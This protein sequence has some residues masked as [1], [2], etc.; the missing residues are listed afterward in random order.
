MAIAVLNPNVPRPNIVIDTRERCLDSLKAVQQARSEVYTTLETE[1]GKQNP[2]QLDQIKDVFQ[3]I[4]TQLNGL[5]QDSDYAIRCMDIHTSKQNTPEL[6]ECRKEDARLNALETKLYETAA[7]K[8][9]IGSVDPTAVPGKPALPVSQRE[10]LLLDTPENCLASLQ[11]VQIH[12]QTAL[13]NLEFNLLGLQSGLPARKRDKVIEILAALERAK[14]LADQALLCLNFYRSRWPATEP[15]NKCITEQEKLVA[16]EKIVLQAAAKSGFGGQAPTQIHLPIPDRID[17]EIDTAANCLKS[18]ETVQEARSHLLNYLSALI[19]QSNPDRFEIE[20]LFQQ[21]HQFRLLSHYCLERYRWTPEVG[22]HNT[23]SH[24]EHCEEEASLDALESTV[25]ELAVEKGWIGRTVS[26]TMID[27]PS[28]EKIIRFCKAH[29]LI[30]LGLAASA[31]ASVGWIPMENPLGSLAPALAGFLTSVAVDPK[32]TVLD[33]LSLSDF[34]LK[35]IARRALPIATWATITA[36]MC[37]TDNVSRAPYLLGTAALIQIGAHYELWK[38]TFS[39]QNLASTAIDG[40]RWWFKNGYTTGPIAAA[41]A[42]AISYSSD[43]SFTAMGL[44]GLGTYGVHAGFAFLHAHR[45]G[46]S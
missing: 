14:E 29:P 33:T 16:R 40:V 7:R 2:A 23:A 20:R 5:K 21:A 8:G 35:N 13:K 27:L 28:T 41:A 12:R 39:V 19:H 24:L 9:W 34:L 15:Y 32:Q 42:G 31:A 22:T 1:L 26:M 25:L 4:L 17:L 44:F 36:C 18:L 38:T 10:D 43:Q 46:A 6:E 30:P 45:G 11:R 37:D 3:T